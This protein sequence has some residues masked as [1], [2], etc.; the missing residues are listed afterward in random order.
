MPRHLTPSRVS[1]PEA[2][3]SVFRRRRLLRRL[4][5]AVPSGPAW[6]FAPAGAG[7]ST[8]V[9]SWLASRRRECVWYRLDEG[10]GEPGSFFNDLSASLG[11]EGRAEVGRPA[12]HAE[13]PETAL[14]VGAR[15]GE[16]VWSRLDRRVLVLDEYERVPEGS[17]FHDLV[18]LLLKSRPKGS[19]LVVASRRPPPAA[20]VRAARPEQLTVI[21]PRELSLTE[22]ETAGVARAHGAKTTARARAELHRR[23]KG[24]AAGVALLVAGRDGAD[25]SALPAPG[26]ASALRDYLRHKIFDRLPPPAQFALLAAALT[27][28]FSIELFRRLTDLTDIPAEVEDLASAGTLVAQIAGAE[29]SYEI[30][31]LFRD[32][33]RG[34]GRAVL[35]AGRRGALVRRAAWLQGE[36]GEWESAVA[37][38]VEEAAWD[39]LGRFLEEGCATMVA[40]GRSAVLARWIDLLPGE[41]LARRP[42]LAY[43]RGSLPFQ[44]E[45]GLRA[46]DRA[47]EQ[48]V[49]AQN[50]DGAYLCAAGAV[51]ARMMA[52]DDLATLDPWIDRVEALRETWPE[53]SRRQVGS[54][55]SFSMATALLFRRPGGPLLRRWLDRAEVLARTAEAP[56]RLM[57]LS[58]LLTEAIW[59]ARVQEAVA[60]VEASPV[61]EQVLAA[62]PVM[63]ARWSLFTSRVALFDG[64]AQQAMEVAERG[65]VAA[66]S[67]GW[68]GIDGL[69]HLVKMGAALQ[70]D[71]LK[72]AAAHLRAAEASSG[73]KRDHL[74]AELALAR[75]VLAFREG[76]GREARAH[77]RHAKEASERTGIS[78]QCEAADVALRVA[79]RLEDR[80]APQGALPQAG[81]LGTPRTWSWL[82]EAA[83]ALE[84]ADEDRAA[85]L[86]AKAFPVAAA[87]GLTYY[88]WLSR[89]RLASL[90]ALALERGIQGTFVTHLVRRFELE[91]PKQAWS[92]MSW[93]W[94]V[95]VRVLG[96]ISIGRI[97]GGAPAGRR[98]QRRPLELLGAL[99]ALGPAPVEDARL[100]ELLWPDAQGDEAARSLE[101][102]LYR[103]RKLVGPGVVLQ[104]HRHLVL[105]RGRCWVDLWALDGL[106]EQ[107]ASVS[108]EQANDLTD[109]VLQ[110]YRGPP[111][112][113]R[114]GQALGAIASEQLVSRV[115]ALV[116]RNL[117]WLQEE[118]QMGRVWRLLDQIEADAALARAVERLRRPAVG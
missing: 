46:A 36:M 82:V 66:R 105:D 76:H 43:R 14:K 68:H 72:A 58:T 69:L 8:L 11:G 37:S 2:G 104:H 77:A 31:P 16:W 49:E 38:L 19:G 103:L 50:A 107:A 111:D 108:G 101:T 30:H 91:A 29:G 27:P 55:V 3:G 67:V 106:L 64:Q 80:E 45:V 78:L 93:P 40:Q 85:D 102:T 48:F 100:A 17:V 44:H 18:A 12:Y 42:W 75:S 54:M 60:M 94:A 6:V 81:T 13:L 118:G 26:D 117:A 22:R 97:G 113:Q 32:F 89:P 52:V 35:D 112:F 99:V 7:K 41:V 57:L 21:D 114:A 33:L 10:D 71:D 116:A 84:R 24:W 98:V 39:D 62:D 56:H 92:G 109:A 28:R 73:Q 115:A 87:G 86:L 47:F 20:L 59:N 61:P 51:I 70:G 4:D 5:L 15:F 23:A 83:Q 65:L 34:H 90:C 96:G 110:V 63:E 88:P 1:R 74:V 9:A 25:P 79:R 53:P 95:Q